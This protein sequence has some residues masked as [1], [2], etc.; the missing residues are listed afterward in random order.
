MN[1]PDLGRHKNISI[2]VHQKCTCI[3]LSKGSPEAMGATWDIPFLQMASTHAMHSLREGHE[4]L[5]IEHVSVCVL[6]RIR[7]CMS[8]CMCLKGRGITTIY[9]PCS[10]CS[11]FLHTQCLNWRCT[12]THTRTRE[13]KR[14]PFHLLQCSSSMASMR[15][16]GLPSAPVSSLIWDHR[17]SNKG[18]ASEPA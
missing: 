4:G 3:W 11:S 12:H 5:S 2:R 9:A 6:A 13:D 14:A 15:R 10:E 7:V 18:P 1:T 16:D 8:A 17:P